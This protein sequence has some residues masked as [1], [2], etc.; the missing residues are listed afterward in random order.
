MRLTVA[1]ARSM[2]TIW[3]YVDT[4]QVGDVNHLKVYWM[5][6]HSIRRKGPQA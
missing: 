3:V 6:H 1:G 4:K 5:L 2:K